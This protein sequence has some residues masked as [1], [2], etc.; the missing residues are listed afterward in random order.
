MT[1]GHLTFQVSGFIIDNPTPSGFN[2][3]YR[4]IRGSPSSDGRRSQLCPKD[5]EGTP[6][7]I[8]YDLG[9]KPIQSRSNFAKELFTS[10]FVNWFQCCYY[11]FISYLPAIDI[12]NQISCMYLN[13]QNYTVGAVFYMDL[14]VD[15]F[16]RFSLRMGS[17]THSCKK[18]AGLV[19]LYTFETLTELQ[20]AT[21]VPRY[22]SPQRNNN[23]SGIDLW[24][25]RFWGGWP[26]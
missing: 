2:S 11:L 14:N 5:F 4:W 22:A 13:A 23:S 12:S 15:P 7:P 24:N 8:L 10:K 25:V 1:I 26:K 21:W 3:T 16:R 17:T 6:H 19:I 9:L 20:L 18:V